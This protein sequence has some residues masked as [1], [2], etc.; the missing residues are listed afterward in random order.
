MKKLQEKPLAFVDVETTGLDP[1]EHTILEIA[2]IRTDTGE[3]STKIK[4][5][6]EDI[7]KASTR[8][9]DVNRYSAEEWKDAPPEG[10]VVAEICKRL[11]G[12]IIVAHNASF[13]KS[14]ITE[15]IKRQ[16]RTEN[17]GY[18]WLDT[19]SYA[20]EHLVPEGLNRLSLNAVCDHAGISNEGAHRALTDARRCKAVYY[21]CKSVH[22]FGATTETPQST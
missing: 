19:V 6:P 21:H 1:Y 20:Y 14:F 11:S 12:V 4:P 15:L 9:L 5:T 18:H 13:D 8:A 16:E 2:I 7:E 3:W 10:D 22:L 17:V